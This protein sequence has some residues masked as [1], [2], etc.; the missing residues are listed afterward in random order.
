MLVLVLVVLH[1]HLHPIHDHRRMV[2]AWAGTEVVVVGTV[3]T[4]GHR[5]LPCRCAT[6]C[7]LCFL[8]ESPPHLTPIGHSDQKWQRRPRTERV[9]GKDGIELHR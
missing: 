3:V 6:L 2:W 7:T 9:G 4:N 5:Y 1:L 8:E